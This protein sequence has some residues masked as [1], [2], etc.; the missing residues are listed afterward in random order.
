MSTAHCIPACLHQICATPFSSLPGPD[1]VDHRPEPYGSICLG[2]SM[3]FWTLHWA[4]YS[5]AGYCAAQG[6]W[7]QHQL[8]IAEMGYFSVSQTRTRVRTH[9][10]TAWHLHTQDRFNQFLPFFER[11]SGSVVAL[12]LIAIGILGIYESHF[13]KDDGH[14]E[15]EQETMKMALAG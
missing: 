9:T 10:H 12:T 3:G 8:A 6:E 13:A 11:W 4:T 2:S 1:P 15:E 7:Q 5:R 14:A